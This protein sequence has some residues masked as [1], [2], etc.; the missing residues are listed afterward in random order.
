MVGEVVIPG[1]PS[2]F[3]ANAELAE[4]H[5]PVLGEH[6]REVARNL[7]GYDD[8]R[9]ADLYERGVLATGQR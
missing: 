5:A 8:A 9:V 1:L 4:L 7:L 2:K 6:S 3:S